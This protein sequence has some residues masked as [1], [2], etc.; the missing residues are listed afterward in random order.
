MFFIKYN[1]SK[2][3]YPNRRNH[4]Y[5]YSHLGAQAFPPKCFIQFW[6]CGLLGH[7]GIHALPPPL[8]MQE[9]QSPCEEVPSFS[10]SSCLLSRDC[11]TV[12]L[13]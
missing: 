4:C 12:R 7:L 9:M 11:S 8:L 5:H 10:I 6:Q 2:D 1:T 13:W 3:R